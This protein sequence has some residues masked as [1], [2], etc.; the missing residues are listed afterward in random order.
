MK[1]GHLMYELLKE[2]YP[3]CRSITGDGVR[4]TL[5]IL[6]RFIPLNSH[7]V[8]SGT[9]VFDWTVPDEWN[10]ND[11]YVL[12]EKGNKVIDFKEN[13]LHVVNYS[14]P[15]DKVIS[16]EKLQEH[17]HS[18]P[19]IPDAI[20]YVTSYYKRYWGF[21][22]S[23]KSRNALKPGD[24]TVKIDS[25]LEPGSLTYGEL[26]IEGETDK[27]ILLSTYICHPSMANNELSGPVLT[28]WLAKE[29]LG[30]STK[31][32]YSYRILFLPETI[33]AITYL[34]KNYKTMKDKTIAGYVITCIGGPDNFTYLS[35]RQGDCLTDKIT[36]HILKAYKYPHRI[37][38]YTERGSD[39]RQYCAPG[40]D[41]P[42]G[43]LMRSKYH[44]YKEY[45]LSNDNLEFV[46]PEQMLESFNV[47]LKCL[48]AIESN[49]KYKITVL[50][51]PQLGKRGLYPNLGAAKK[52]EVE[53]NDIM[54]IIGYSDGK[55][56]LLN[57]AE[58]HGRP[59]KA[60]FK[61][62]RQMVEA[63]LLMEA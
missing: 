28:T 53:Q 41:L 13:N 4:E 5:D 57:I 52:I 25:T 29:L 3:I 18:Y 22:L 62:V 9:K 10:I 44:E 27:E 58:I 42:I 46:T 19:S 15:I 43:S 51:E 2:L 61:P 1:S 49:R 48:E 45:H 63:G 16:L 17:L 55:H 20:P 33:G 31:P 50:C 8:P 11:A 26:L 34:S 6:K 40:I 56:D 39:E 47:Y 32:Y 38:P 60:Y 36:K 12:D 30:K 14:I 23:E 35:S 7:E 54:A 21:C 24:Y 59:I 37:L